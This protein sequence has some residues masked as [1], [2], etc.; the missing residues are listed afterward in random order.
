M[1]DYLISFNSYKVRY[2]HSFKYALGGIELK[3]QFLQGKV[4]TP[5]PMVSIFIYNKFQFLQGKVQ[6]GK[7]DKATVTVIMFQF[8]QGKVQT[9]CY[10]HK[11]KKYYKVS[12]PTR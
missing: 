6:T 5:M 8:L 1:L 11:N 7:Y 10:S 3:F 12:I 4:Q 9:E 2:K